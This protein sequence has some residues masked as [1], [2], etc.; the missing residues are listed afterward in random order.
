L[1]EGVRAAGIVAALMLAI[2][3][4]AATRLPARLAQSATPT[5]T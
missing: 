2:G 5:E 4:I 1:D 3:L